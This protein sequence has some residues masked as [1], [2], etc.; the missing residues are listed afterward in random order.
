MIKR[1]KVIE[2]SARIERLVRKAYISRKKFSIASTQIRKIRGEVFKLSMFQFFIPLLFYIVALVIY[3]IL[4]IL[5]F[6]QYI[7][8]IDLNNVCLVPPPIGIP[9]Q[10]YGCRIWIVWIHFLVFVLY[11][12]LYDYYTKKYLS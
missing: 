3:A 8:V 7:D 1:Y 6:K 12:P 10:S 2:Q 9:L 4:S 11:L 5:I